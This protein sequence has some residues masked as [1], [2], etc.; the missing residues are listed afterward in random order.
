M[1]VRKMR[2][3]KALGKDV[4]KFFKNLVFGIFFI[5]LAIGWIFGNSL[6]FENPDFTFGPDWFLLAPAILVNALIVFVVGGFAFDV[7]LNWFTE[8]EEVEENV[9]D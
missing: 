8:L 4:L 7:G 9:S 3:M 5:Y 6:L 2:P 1:L